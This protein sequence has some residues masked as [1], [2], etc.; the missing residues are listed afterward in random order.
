MKFLK[1][2]ENGNKNINS[3]NDSF[4]Q[5]AQNESNHKFAEEA[6]FI[7]IVQAKSKNK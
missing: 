4:N 7:R 5:E 6:K 1:S 3:L 2:F